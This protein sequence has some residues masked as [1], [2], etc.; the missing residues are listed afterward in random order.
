[1]ITIFSCFFNLDF[2]LALRLLLNIFQIYYRYQQTLCSILKVTPKK[3]RMVGYAACV[4]Q[5]STAYNVLGF[6]T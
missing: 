5:M 1:M 4:A 6:N 2:F 3:M